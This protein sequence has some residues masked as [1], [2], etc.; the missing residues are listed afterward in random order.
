MWI[1]NSSY[2]EFRTWMGSGDIKLEEIGT[3]YNNKG[4]PIRIIVKCH[5][6]HQQDLLESLKRMI[7]ARKEGLLATLSEIDLYHQF[8]SRESRPKHI[9]AHTND[10]KEYLHYVETGWKLELVQEQL[11]ML[12]D[13][14]RYISNSATE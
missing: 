3:R 2:E 7:L 14:E 11:D 4:E 1:L 6:V 9:P 12:K 8:T 10:S 13:T 5:S